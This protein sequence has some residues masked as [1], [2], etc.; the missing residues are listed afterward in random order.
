AAGVTSASTTAPAA[1]PGADAAA[2]GAEA[3]AAG[4][5]AAAGFA[6]KPIESQP[7]SASSAAA[8]R[9]VAGRRRSADRIDG[10]LRVFALA[11]AHRLQG[12]QRGE[13]LL[14]ALRPEAFGRAVRVQRVQLDR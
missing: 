1:S 14:H 3:D 10:R 13:A 9:Q 8:A 6:R 12:A 11:P 2:P 4:T 7:A 5:G